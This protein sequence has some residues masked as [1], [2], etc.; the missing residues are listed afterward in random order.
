MEARDIMSEYAT[1]SAML[2]RFS[3]KELAE[4]CDDT[5]LVTAEIMKT[6]IDGGDLSG[7]SEEEQSAVAAAM[8]RLSQAG[9]DADSAVNTYLQSG[10]YELPLEHG[11]NFITDLAC[12]IA[13]YNLADITE[14]RDTD[15]IWRRYDAAMKTLGKI[16]SGALK[17]GIPAKEIST[18][19][20]GQPTFSA[21]ARVFSH[22]TLANY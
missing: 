4:R 21:P 18:S 2:K 6:A 9:Q 10:G 15:V 17:V 13:L 22:T 1:P 16:A 14:L 12:N 3:A 7:Y 11:V 19:Y 5:P 8:Q 20:S